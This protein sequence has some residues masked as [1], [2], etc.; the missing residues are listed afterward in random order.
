MDQL[1]DYALGRCPTGD[2]Q[3]MTSPLVTRETAT[4]TFPLLEL[5]PELRAIVF[6]LLI[7]A[8]DLSILRVSKLISQEAVSLLS[9]VG[10]LRINLDKQ[11]KRHMTIA[12]TAKTTLYGELTLAAPDYIQNLDICLN[13]VPGPDI[14]VNTTLIQYFKGRRI[15][16]RSCKITILFGIQ[17][18][19]TNPLEENHPYRVISSLVSFKSLTLKLKYVEDER[20][21]ALILRRLDRGLIT[22][23]ADLTY[24]AL[25]RDY[26][27]ASEFLSFKLGPAKLN[28]R[29]GEPYLSFKPRGYK[30]PLHGRMPTWPEDPETQL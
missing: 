18:P 4:R 3:T 7:Q 25:S 22:D 6:E 13:L 17:G 26:K 1:L 11:I 14:P 5:P 20:W 2:Y 29:L 9:K 24:K 27:R 8:G 23:D 16:R 10:I 21:E 28:D 12:L 19:A 15:A 30:P